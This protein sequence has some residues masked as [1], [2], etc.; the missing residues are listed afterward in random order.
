MKKIVSYHGNLYFDAFEQH[1]REIKEKSFNIILFCITETD[2]QFN[3]ETFREFR[4]YAEE[5]GLQCWATFWGLTAGE[6]ICKDCDLNKWLFCVK[7]IGFNNIFIDEPKNKEDIYKFI[8][9]DQFFNL[10]L[11]LTDDGFNRTTDEEIR[12]LPVKSVGVSCYHWVKDWQK[13]VCRS[14]L[15]SSRLVK[16]RPYNNFIFIQGFDIPDGWEALPH[17]VKEV[18]E[19]NGVKDFGF[20]SFRSTEATAIKRP[21][22]YKQIWDNLKI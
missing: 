2:I 15:I 22:N 8:E 11:C 7:S 19:S 18:A 21:A 20:W 14:S 6:A 16:L 4:I 12:A 1:V 9:Y 3:L 10:H 5:Q 17:I 13:I